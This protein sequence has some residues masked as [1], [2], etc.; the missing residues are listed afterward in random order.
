M[1]CEL[2][3]EEMRDVPVSLSSQEVRAEGNGDLCYQIQTSK[4]YLIK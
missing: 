1:E 3:V 2:A 4:G